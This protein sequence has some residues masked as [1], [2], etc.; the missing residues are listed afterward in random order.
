MSCLTYQLNRSVGRPTFRYEMTRLLVMFGHYKS[1]RALKH[2]GILGIQLSIY[3][4]IRTG[5]KITVKCSNDMPEISAIT[6][7]R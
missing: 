6:C 5:S 3:A 1:G 2:V 7:N 4:G